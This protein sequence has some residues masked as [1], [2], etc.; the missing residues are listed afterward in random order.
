M[1]DNMSKILKFIGAITVT[2]IIIVAGFVALNPGIV[3]GIS[4]VLD[5]GTGSGITGN[6]AGTG[7]SADIEIENTNWGD[8]TEQDLSVVSDVSVT[9]PVRSF[10]SELSGTLSMNGYE[11]ATVT[12]PQTTIEEGTSTVTVTSSVS[13][14]NMATWWES[15][16]NNDETSDVNI[17]M[18]GDFSKAGLSG[19]PSATKH[20]EFSTGI[21]DSLRGSLSNAEGKKVNGKIILEDTGA[22]WGEVNEEESEVK[23]RFTV[24]NNAN[25][26]ILITEFSGRSQ[27]NEIRLLEWETQRND[28][29]LR[30][31]ETTEIDVVATVDNEKIDDWFASHIQQEEISNYEHHISLDVEAADTSIPIAV[32]SGEMKTDFL[33]DNTAGLDRNGCDTPDRSVDFSPPDFNDDSG[34]GSNVDVGDNID[35]ADGSNGGT[36]TDDSESD[37]NS[38]DTNEAPTAVIE[39]S[40]QSGEAPL[41]VKFDASGSSDPDGTIERYIWRV[42]GGNLPGRGQSLERTFRTQGQYDITLIT[43]DDSG[44]RDSSTITVDVERRSLR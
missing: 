30:R 11:M 19:N 34:V 13:R 32:C 4:V 40:P 14:N 27:F 42:D 38:E 22:E 1:F 37:E 9:N 43:V 2:A 12:T 7:E 23:V 41:D 39:A 20:K 21:I 31:G 16:V 18:S 15:H 5:S 44:N 33:V 28:R 6:D 8:V 36:S 24:T 29:T 10:Q 17:Q 35:V 25:V 3:S 26:P